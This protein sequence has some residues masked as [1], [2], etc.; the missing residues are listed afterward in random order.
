MKYFLDSYAL[1]EIAEG[2]PAYSPYLESDVVTL[3]ENLAELF[4]FLIKKYDKNVAILFLE[5]FSKIADDLPLSLIS[6]A[7]IFRY[8]HKDKKFSYIDCFGYTYATENKIIFLTGDRG[9]KDKE[10]VKIVR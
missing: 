6:K 10:G 4:Y 2:N 1:I 5:K 7:M 9:F 3:K 8:E